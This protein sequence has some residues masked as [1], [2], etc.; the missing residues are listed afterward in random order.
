MNTFQCFW[1][2]KKSFIKLTT[3][4]NIFHS[5]GPFSL[6]G[7]FSIIRHFPQAEIQHGWHQEKE[8]ED[9]LLLSSLA[10][11]KIFGRTLMDLLK[12]WRNYF[13]ASRSSRYQ[14]DLEQRPQIIQR[15]VNKMKQLWLMRF[16]FGR[17][18]VFFLIRIKRRMGGVKGRVWA[19]K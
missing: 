12:H 3:N 16:C 6:E 11:C 8:R 10:G 14:S 13:S 2:T 5:Y 19:L 1:T 17:E 7:I 15:I 9:I 18:N 4:S